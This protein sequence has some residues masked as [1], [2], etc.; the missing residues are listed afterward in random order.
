MAAYAVMVVLLD[1]LSYLHYPPY[2]L[3]PPPPPPFSPSHLGSG[4]LLHLHSL[5]FPIGQGMPLGIS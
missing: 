4:L 5:H 3:S 1:H 2:N